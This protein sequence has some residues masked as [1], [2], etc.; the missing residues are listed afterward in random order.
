LLGDAHNVAH[1]KRKTNHAGRKAEVN[2][3]AIS[4]KRFLELL[5]PAEAG[6]AISCK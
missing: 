2:C 4:E 6:R 5:S 3:N 1:P